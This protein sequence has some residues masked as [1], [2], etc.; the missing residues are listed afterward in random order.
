MPSP[1]ESPRPDIFLNRR[2]TAPTVRLIA[3][4]L[5]KSSLQTVPSRE[6]KVSQRASLC[7]VYLPN[8]THFYLYSDFL[9]YQLTIL[10]LN[11]ESSCLSLLRTGAVVALHCL[12]PSKAHSPGLERWLSG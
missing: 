9:L 7:S 2:H 3:F 10:A 6:E 11:L 1:E 5:T 12:G 4:A 8:R